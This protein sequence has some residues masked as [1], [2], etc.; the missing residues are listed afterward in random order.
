MEAR[1]AKELLKGRVKKY[2]API[3]DIKYI[4]LTKYLNETILPNTKKPQT[5]A[6]DEYERLKNY[7]GL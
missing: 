2:V 6:P 4:K 7:L 3:V 1:Q 5:L